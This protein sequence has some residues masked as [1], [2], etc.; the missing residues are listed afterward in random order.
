MSLSVFPFRTIKKRHKK[1][2]FFQCLGLKCIDRQQLAEKGF[3][4]LHLS[5]FILYML[6]ANIY[7]SPLIQNKVVGVF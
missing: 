5:Q 4:S 7:H 6:E 1:H 3:V 2:P